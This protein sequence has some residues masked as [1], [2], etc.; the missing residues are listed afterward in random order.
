ML[1]AQHSRVL[2][3]TIL[4]FFPGAGFQDSKATRPVDVFKDLEGHWAG[5]FVGYDTT[6]KE[7][8]RIRVKQWYRTVNATTQEV[9]LEDTL[10]DGTVITGKGQNLARRVDGKLQ[11]TCRVEKS[12]GDKVEHQGRLVRGPEGGQQLVWSTK[13]KDRTETFRE[14]V[15]KS[16]YHIHGLGSYGGKLMLMAGRYQHQD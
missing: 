4:L 13:T 6:G 2:L 9:R 3:A 11:L 14:W 1:R 8:Y 10:A 7:L 12:N 5:T 15:S 16:T